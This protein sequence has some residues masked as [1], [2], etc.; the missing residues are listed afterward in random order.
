MSEKLHHLD[1]FPEQLGAYVFLPGD[2][3]RA[4]KIA[5]HLEG[6]QLI[7]ASR[8]FV[9]YTGTLAGEKVSVTS[10]GIG[11]PSAAIAME[12]LS[13]SGAH[14][15]L[16][17][18]TCGG[19]QPSLLPGD[20][21][22]PSAAIRKDGTAREYMPLSFPAV[23]DFSMLS[24]LKEAADQFQYRSHVGIVECKDSYYGQHDPGSMPVRTTL[25][26]Q[27]NMWKEAG[28]LASEMESS[29]LFVVAA[30]R[31]VRCATVLLLVSNQE[32]SFAPG[33]VKISHDIQRA[34]QTGVQAMKTVILNDRRGRL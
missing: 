2:P 22:L 15:F 20:L 11:G 27:W 21:I 23:P 13:R 25:R 1:C 31:H 26:E 28:A 14:T 17:I 4:E 18:G 7:S 30:V 5:A 6:A 12:E 3:G 32:R 9:T 33:E 10:T 8:E 16:R 34:I 24:A 29:T 19:I